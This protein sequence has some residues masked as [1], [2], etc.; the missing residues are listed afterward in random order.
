MTVAHDAPA[1]GKH[2]RSMSA[3]EGCECSLIAVKT[4]SAQQL[5]IRDVASRGGACHLAEIVEDRG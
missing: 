4:E 5:G 1:H 2:H 3:H